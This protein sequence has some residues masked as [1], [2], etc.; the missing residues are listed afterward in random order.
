MVCRQF[1]IT[2]TVKVLLSD[3]LFIVITCY[4]PADDSRK[5]DFLQEMISLTP[6]RHS[7]WLILG[8]FNLIYKASDK[9]NLNLNRRL[10]GKFRAALD[11]CEL[12]EI[13]LQN[14]K[15]TWSNERDNP[16]L[17]RLDRAF[18]NAD[19]EVLF[20]DFAFHA[21]ST[22]ASDHC[23]IL[24]SRQ[25]R[26]PTKAR[27][28]FENHWLHITGFS[29]VVATAWAKNQQG[30]AHTVLRKKL[31]HTASELGNGASRCSVTV[32]YSCTLQMRSSYGW[33]WCRRQDNYLVQR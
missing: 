3:A 22:G 30:S 33:R 16:T 4:G 9:N 1:S 5:E 7:P 24:L 21:L 29:E 28:R 15:F 19:W 10:M 26:E 31:A 18:C 32:G 23:L 13:C 27:F 6:T 17:V 8:D 2:A 11:A 25:H 20:P 12:M 14:R